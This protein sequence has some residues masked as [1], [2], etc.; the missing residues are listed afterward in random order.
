MREV[1]TKE[2][3]VREEK[4]LARL[5][6]VKSSLSSS[7][8][9]DT[10]TKNRVDQR[11]REIKR[12]KR[13]TG[14]QLL[15]NITDE[16]IRVPTGAGVTLCSEL[17]TCGLRLRLS[18][19]RS[20]LQR[21]HEEPFIGISYNP[22]RLSTNSAATRFNEVLP[23]YN[24]RRGELRHDGN[25]YKHEQTSERLA[26]SSQTYEDSLAAVVDCF[27]STLN[28]ID[29]KRDTNGYLNVNGTKDDYLRLPPMSWNS[30]S[31]DGRSSSSQTTLLQCKTGP[32]STCSSSSAPTEIAPSTTRKSSL[33]DS[34]AS[35]AETVH[36]LNK[37]NSSSK[38]KD[39][40]NV[41][42]RI[43]CIQDKDSCINR[44]NSI[45]IKRSC[46][47]GTKGLQD[48]Q[49]EREEAMSILQDFNDVSA[50]NAILHVEL[51]DDCHNEFDL[52]ERDGLSSPL[53]KESTYSAEE[54]FNENRGG[55][56]WLSS[57]A[58]S[59]SAQEIM[60]EGT[61][62]PSPP[63]QEEL[64][65]SAQDFFVD[66]KYSEQQGSKGKSTSN[67]NEKP[68]PPRNEA[69]NELSSTATD[70][71]IDAS[72]NGEELTRIGEAN[73]SAVHQNEKSGR[74]ESIESISPNSSDVD[75]YSLDED[76]SMD[77]E[78]HT[79]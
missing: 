24:E 57:K 75:G 43:N 73:N 33:E 65:Y 41:K 39:S 36:Q 51:S 10:W 9:H 12:Q 29:D 21:W 37:A 34:R 13:L 19:E 49:K 26:S 63:S 7:T 74:F 42:N 53:S 60:S 79:S 76:F 50:M 28:V 6:N 11:A 77:A 56:S 59:Y 47:F 78:Q 30:D 25:G 22:E 5:R 46:L 54:S 15:K 66:D 72:S 17:T 55:P 44:E 45:S 20:R 35:N 23:S 8:K 38:Y 32:Y 31:T 64:P 69:K 62:D 1:W 2:R 3:A 71:E 27:T 16:G 4:R 58:L 52:G 68:F 70:T 40:L 14:Q 67:A 61:D 48:L 18:S